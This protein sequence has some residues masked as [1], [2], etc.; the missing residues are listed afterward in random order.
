MGWYRP[1]KLGYFRGQQFNLPEAKCVHILI[2]NWI[3]W[4]IID[5]H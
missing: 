1:L 2:I 3:Y 4:M 5:D